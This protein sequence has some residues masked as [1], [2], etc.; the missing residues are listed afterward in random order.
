M[1]PSYLKRNTLIKNR[2][3]GTLIKRK[4]IVG[5]LQDLF[6]FTLDPSPTRSPVWTLSLGTGPRSRL[7]SEP[8]VVSGFPFQIT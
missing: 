1:E 5:D 2:K 6:F 4:W 7:D 3:N 8:A